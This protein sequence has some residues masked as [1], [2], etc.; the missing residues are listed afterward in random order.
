MARTPKLTPELIDRI[1]K[2]V[3]LRLSWNKIGHIV[4][5]TSRTLYNWR[6]RGEKLK[7]TSRSIY[8]KFVN[9]VNKAKAEADEEAA[10]VFY[11]AMIGGE[12]TINRKVVLENG[13]VVKTEITEKTLAPNWKA[14]LA[15]LERADPETWGRYEM[16]RLETDLR[17]EVESL[18]LDLEDVLQAA[19]QLIES[20][21]DPAKLTG[22]EADAVIPAIAL[23]GNVPSTE[24]D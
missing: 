13:I 2:L 4:G 5:V 22:T 14:A 8:R 3:K 9:A 23:P 24:E 6:E 12:K 18:G 16:L 11:K 19:M 7:P 20:L 15:W 21:V 10:A 17:V 1:C